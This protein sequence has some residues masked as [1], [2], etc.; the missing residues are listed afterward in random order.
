MYVII[1]II[2][3]IINNNVI[4]CVIYSYI[5]FKDVCSLKFP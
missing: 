3:I 4:M 1:I 5:L 2:I